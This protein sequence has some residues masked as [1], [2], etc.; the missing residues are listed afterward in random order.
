MLNA[1]SQEL[2]VEGIRKCPLIPARHKD[3]YVD[4]R[5]LK[6][7]QTPD[8]VSLNVTHLILHNWPNRLLC[9]GLPGMGVFRHHIWST[10]TADSAQRGTGRLMM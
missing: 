8:R 1:L 6:V 10:S 9:A 3:A 4:K 7:S 5:S 2:G